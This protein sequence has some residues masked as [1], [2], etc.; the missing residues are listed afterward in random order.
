RAVAG[1]VRE[2]RDRAQTAGDP[3]PTAAVLCRRRSQFPVLQAALLGAGLPVEVVGLGG[4]LSTP[5]VVDLVAALQCAH[6]PSRGD[7]LMRLLT[8]PRVRLG[9]AD[10]HAL[11]DR[12]TEL[13]GPR[14]VRDPRDPGGPAPDVVDERSIVDALDDLPDPTWVS[15]RG[16]SLSDLGHRRLVGLAGVLRAL[17]EQ[18]F[19]PVV[20]LVAEAERLLDLDI[21]VAARPGTHHAGARANLDAF[22]SVA[23]SFGDSD[24]HGTLG[25][26]LAWLDAAQREERGLE[27]PVAEIDPEAVQLLTV[28]AAKG[29]EWDVV[30][31]PGLVDKTFPGAPRTTGW[32]KDRGALPTSLRGDRD[33]LPD[34]DVAP[35]LEVAELAERFE[36]YTAA[37]AVH[38]HDEERRLAYVALTRARTHLMLS[39]SWWREGSRPTE[40]SVF[41][42]ELTDGAGEGAP[43]VTL[44]TA[45]PDPREPDEHG[46]PGRATKPEPPAVEPPTWPPDDL[47]RP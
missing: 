35:G 38:H 39:G 41:L 3:V 23:A 7:A 31:V 21:E 33:S 14:P 13:A 43:V 25:A 12:A 34:V 8:G 6:D 4:L 46:R 10:L 24:E 1:F 2:H 29:L 9:L 30:A 36:A 27:A 40:P 18:T 5:E 15:P 20:D 17:R 42:T 32:I 22:R 26:F 44:V 45:A 28:H 37:H 47:G 19:L 16:R 11:S